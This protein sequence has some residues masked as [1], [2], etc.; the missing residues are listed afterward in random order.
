MSKRFKT[1]KKKNLNIIKL[2]AI[3]MIIYI[4]FNLTYNIVYKLYLSKLDNK[5]IIKHIIENN[6]SNKVSNNIIDKYITPEKILN[7]NFNIIKEELIE[8]VIN[9][10][11]PPI[12]YIYSTHESESYK[13][14]YLEVYNIKPTVK[15]MSYILQEYLNDYGLTT[16]VE[17]GSVTK[18]LKDNKWPYRNSYLASKKLIEQTIKENESLKLIIDLHRDSSSL[19]KTLINEKNKKYAR[20]LFVIG[21]EHEN[22]KYNLEVATKLNK[23]LKEEIPNISRGILKKSG[24]GVNGIY[25]QDLSKKSILIELGGQYNEIEELNNTIELLAKSILKYLEGEE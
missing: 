1:R 24:E 23:I 17:E 15:T 6:K 22:Y 18:I 12:I 13:D 16:I 8:P 21:E 19:E 10:K 3:I 25:N 9:I 11:S 20:I 5:E 7:N 4:S 14:P 2:I